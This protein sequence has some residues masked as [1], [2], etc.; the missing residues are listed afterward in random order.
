MDWELV[1]ITLFILIYFYIPMMA[2]HFNLLI[3]HCGYNNIGSGHTYT[4]ERDEKG[5]EDERRDE[6]GREEKKRS[7]K[8][9][10]RKKIIE[11]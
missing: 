3:I 2:G 1:K 7:E 9:R 8:T 4:N 10:T 6:K 5:R 11:Q